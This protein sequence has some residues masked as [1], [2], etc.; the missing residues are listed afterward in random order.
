VLKKSASSIRSRLA[1]RRLQGSHRHG[2]YLF[3]GLEGDGW[4]VLHFGMTGDLHHYKGDKDPPGHERLRLSLNDG[5]NL[6][7]SCPRLLGAVD[8]AEDVGEFINE[9]SLGPDAFDLDLSHFRKRL[10]ARSGAIKSVLMN[11]KVLA[12]LG[13][14]YT[15]EVLFQAGV[16]PKAPAGRLDDEQVRGLHRGM[17]RILH[18]AIESR[19]DPARMPSSWLLPHREPEASCPRCAATLKRITVGGRQG[20]CCPSCQNSRQAGGRTRGAKASAS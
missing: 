18:Q 6:G 10:S 1:G 19:A 15:D 16:H 13:N 9:R 8:L 2:K 3:A 11:Q 14:V 5:W 12:G 7:Y 17:H 4:V 20:Y